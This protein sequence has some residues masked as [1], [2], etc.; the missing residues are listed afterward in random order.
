MMPA[1]MISVFILLSAVA[2]CQGCGGPSSIAVQDRLP[3]ISPVWPSPPEKPR[4]RHLYSIS[5]ADDVGVAP[6]L[7][8]KVGSFLTGAEQSR[9]MTR[10]HGLFFGADEVLCIADPGSGSVHLFDT[11]NRRYQEITKYGKT[12]L[13]S[14]IGVVKDDAGLLYVSDSMLRKVFVFGSKGEPIREIG[15][16]EW[17]ARPTGLAVSNSLKRLYVTDTADHCIKVFD[18][19]GHFLF[20]FGKRGTDKGEFNF[21]ASIVIDGNG[22][23]YIN[24]SLNYRIQVF[25]ADGG[26]I[27]LFGRHGDGM[28]EFSSPKGVALDTEGDIYVADAIFDSVQVFDKQGNLLLFFGETGQGPGELW[29]PSALFIDRKNRIFVS[30]SYNQRVQVFQFLGGQ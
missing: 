1:K 25:N 3:S 14:P 17:F 19:D 10:P 29:I 26:F 28:G 18:L 24:D 5:K 20:S 9:R 7:F 4:I 22:D 2:A 12:Q 23:L 8:Q 27:R 13:L 30:D 6:S 21:P 15:G 11:K 16:A